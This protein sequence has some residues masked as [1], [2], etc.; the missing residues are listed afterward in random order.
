MNIKENKEK[1]LA[2]KDYAH[3]IKLIWQQITVNH[4]REVR[5]LVILSFFIAILDGIVPLISGHFFDAITN[6]STDIGSVWFAL[7]LLLVVTAFSAIGQ[8]IK[9][10]KSDWVNYKIITTYH[11]DVAAKFVKLPVSYLKNHPM[12]EMVQKTMTAGNN[13]QSMFSD[14]IMELLPAFLG[15]IVAFVTVFTINTNMSLVLLAGVLTYVLIVLRTVGDGAKFQRENQKQWV[16]AWRARSDGLNNIATV[17]QFA[18]EEYETE[19]NR[20]NYTVKVLGAQRRLWELWSKI[21]ISQKIIVLATQAVILILSIKMLQVNSLTPGQV[22]AFNAYVGMVFNPFLRLGNMW[23]TIQNSIINVSDAHEILSIEPENYNEP[24]AVKK[25]INGD[26]EFKSVAFFH[27]ERKLVLDDLSFSA[28]SGSVIAF[29]GKTG[30]GKTSL[31]ELIYR[32]HDPKT[33]EILVDGIPIDK[34][35]LT[36]LRSQIGIVP[37]EPVLFDT[38]IRENIMYPRKDVNQK[39]LNDAAKKADLLEFIKDQPDG[40]ETIVGDRGV[41]L[42]G[43]QK[44]RIAIARALVAN[45]KILI[46]DESTSALDAE[47]QRTIEN[48]LKE[49]MKGKTT[50]IVAHRL[51]AVRNADK[52][53]VLHKGKIVEEGTHDELIQIANGRYKKLYDL[54]FKEEEILIAEHE[55]E[56]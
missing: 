19:K 1:K 50:F 16:H 34:Y 46:L 37:Q 31:T 51:S 44:Q 55:L 28:P 15:I 2:L 14:V 17:K 30:S 5:T 22:I 40:W 35:Y 39:V 7:I 45:P 12:S 43:G 53:C 33:G 8:K 21:N 47:T 25:Q 32:F 49:L 54:Q 41:K 38:T 9:V 56:D 6:I 24:G 13:L 11:S 3:G 48:S 20:Q 4:K 52:I 23:R 42:S 18:A 26:V 36:S 29:V 10:T 27:D